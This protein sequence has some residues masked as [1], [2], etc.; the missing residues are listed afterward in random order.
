M[1]LRLAFSRWQLDVVY[2]SKQLQ[3]FQRRPVIV[4]QFVLWQICAGC[5]EAAVDGNS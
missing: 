3:N 1:T 4:V 2:S 5:G